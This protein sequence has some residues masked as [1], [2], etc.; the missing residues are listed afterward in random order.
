MTGPY[1]ATIRNR[2]KLI[3]Y[4]GNKLYSGIEDIGSKL[5]Q[6]EVLTKRLDAIVKQKEYYHIHKID[7]AIFFSTVDF[8]RKR[9]AEWCNLPLTTLM[10]SSPGE[11]YAGKTLDYT[12]DTLPVELSWSKNERK[13]FL[14][15]SS[16]FYLELRLLIDKVD[17][18]FSIYNSFRKENADFSHLTEFQHIEFE[19]KVNF[20]ENVSIFLDLLRYITKYIATNNRQ[21]LLYFLSEEEIDS[22]IQSFDQKRVNSITLKEALKLLFDSTNDSVYHKFSLKYFGPWEEIKLTEL[23]KGHVMITEFPILQ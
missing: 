3:N 4:K 11:V 20:K 17:K 1:T 16:Q 7:N 19:G 23:L 22:L 21:D 12:T 18:V 9:G 8:F 6:E 14:S 10:I 5:L 13:I 15:E 2:K